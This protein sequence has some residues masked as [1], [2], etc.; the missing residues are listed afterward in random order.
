MSEPQ[1]E[2]WNHNTAYHPW[3]LRQVPRPC[4]LAVDVGCG[5]GLLLNRLAERVDRVIGID[6]NHPAVAMARQRRA[7]LPHVT[8]EEADVRT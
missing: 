4:R 1:G 3:L 7:G 5:D 6:R 8:V 2:Y